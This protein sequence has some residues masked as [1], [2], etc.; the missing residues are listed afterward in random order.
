MGA[1]TNIN[2]KLEAQTFRLDLIKKF[3]KSFTFSAGSAQGP[4]KCFWLNSNGAM[5][6]VLCFEAFCLFEE[7]KV[8]LISESFLLWHKSPKMGSKSLP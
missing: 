8:G 2:E 5:K 6:E 7:F 3:G 4:P 1:V